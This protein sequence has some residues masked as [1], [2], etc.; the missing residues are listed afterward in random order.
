MTQFTKLIKNLSAQS[1]TP[2]TPLVFLTTGAFNPIH[3]GHLSLFRIAKQ[4]IENRAEYNDKYVVIAGFISPSHDHYLQNKVRREQA[5]PV[6]D[7]ITMARIAIEGQQDLS[8]WV[9]VDE[10]EA[11][12]A[13][14]L[15]YWEVTQ[16]MQKKLN[17]D[18]L[19]KILKCGQRIGVMYLC[20]SDHVINKGAEKLD[21]NG[22]FVVGRSTDESWKEKCEQTLNEKYSNWKDFV[23]FAEGQ[24]P[25]ISSTVIRAYYF[26]GNWQKIESMWPKTVADYLQDKMTITPSIPE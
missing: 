2:K 1:D 20:G 15:D 23:I 14:F 10:C 16:M 25:K 26:C 12:S 7:R 8:S 18:V 21:Q 9:D 11:K 19:P 6:D 13:K 4:S 17:G 3:N 24:Y 22:I 5:I